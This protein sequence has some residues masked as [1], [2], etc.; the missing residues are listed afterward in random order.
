M[1]Y[2]GTLFNANGGTFLNENGGGAK[3]LLTK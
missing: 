1:R 2:S 3:D